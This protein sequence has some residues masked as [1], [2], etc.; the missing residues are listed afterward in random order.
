M[1]RKRFRQCDFSSEIEARATVSPHGTQLHFAKKAP[2]A[3]RLAHVEKL[4]ASPHSE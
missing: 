3:E 1:R 4:A 2:L